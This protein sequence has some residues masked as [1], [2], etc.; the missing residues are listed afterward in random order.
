MATADFALDIS[1]TWSAKVPRK[2]GMVVVFN[3]T[4]LTKPG[5]VL[6]GD[7]EQL[8]DSNK[9]FFTLGG[10]IEGDEIKLSLTFPPQGTPCAGVRAARLAPRS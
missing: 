2:G 8:H 1:G 3:F 5:G 10:S 6:E 7:G 9:W 4:L